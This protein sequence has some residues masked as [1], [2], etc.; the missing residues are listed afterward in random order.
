MIITSALTAS[1]NLVIASSPHHKEPFLG[2]KNNVAF[3]ISFL[4]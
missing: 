4:V 1:F 2:G 3:I